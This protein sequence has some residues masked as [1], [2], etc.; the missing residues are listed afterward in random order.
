MTARLTFNRQQI[1]SL[2]AALHAI[3]LALVASEQNATDSG[4]VVDWSADF[5]VRAS[6]V[7][8][9]VIVNVDP[10]YK[11]DPDAE[12][13]VTQYGPPDEAD[14]E[15]TFKNKQAAFAAL[16]TTNKAERVYRR[17]ATEWKDCGR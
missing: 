10:T 3:H 4:Y 2:P 9:E 11:P 13:Y 6:V 5:G 1:D 16:S 17:T 14:I 7:D 12:W 8:G 15:E